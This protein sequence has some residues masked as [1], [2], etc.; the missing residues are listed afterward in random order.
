MLVP[1][2]VHPDVNPA[3]R[4]TKDAVLLNEAYAVLQLVC[5]LYCPCSFS[6]GFWLSPLGLNADGIIGS[7]FEV[8]KPL[9]LTIQGCGPDARVLPQEKLMNA[10][11]EWDRW[12][13]G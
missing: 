9:S 7:I 6:T 8:F 1:A 5:P 10:G 3:L 13:A 2:Q 11:V 4:S 12:S